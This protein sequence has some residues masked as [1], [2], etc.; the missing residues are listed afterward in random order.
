M[1]PGHRFVLVLK[2]AHVVFV[3]LNLA[4]ATRTR[5]SLATYR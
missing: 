5:V 3:R 2:R 1:E 4:A